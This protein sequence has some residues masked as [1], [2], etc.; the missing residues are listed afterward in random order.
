[1]DEY[2]NRKYRARIT[3]VFAR[4]DEAVGTDFVKRY[5]EWLSIMEAAQVN[6][7]KEIPAGISDCV[8]YLV[9]KSDIENG[10]QQKTF[11]PKDLIT[12]FT[13]RKRTSLN[14]TADSHTISRTKTK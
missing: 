13:I 14:T 1:M 7:R 12:G 4:L 6:Y 8:S 10:S 3:G 2:F 11:T 5:N 9:K